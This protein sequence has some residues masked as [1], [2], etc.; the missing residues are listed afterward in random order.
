MARWGG[1]IP[2]AMDLAIKSRWDAIKTRCEDPTNVHYHRYGG[3]GIGLSDEF[4]DP[5]VFV[6]YVKS[7]PNAS[8]TL[9]I[10][11]IDN[12]RGYVRGNIRWVDRR[13]NVYNEDRTIKV[14]YNG[15]AMSLSHF[16][17]NYTSLSGEYVRNLYHSGKSL[18]EIAS[19]KKTN[20][21]L[22]PGERRPQA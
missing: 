8:L 18:D 11:R 4:H 20:P 13:T 9:E 2:D 6:A 15:E 21:G 7:L 12:S 3:R 22:R 14:T 5:R 19:W 17:R 10:D 16:A 1:I